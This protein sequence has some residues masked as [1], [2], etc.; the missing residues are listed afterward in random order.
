MSFAKK[1]EGLYEMEISDE[2]RQSEMT[3]VNFKVK[4][5]T[6]HMLSAIAERFH[7][8][9]HSFGGEILDDA[10]LQMFHALSPKDRTDLAEKADEALTNAMLKAG[11]KCEGIS[12]ALGEYKNQ[13]GPWR[14]M[15]HLCNEADE[16]R[17]QEASK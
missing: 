14:V 17:N 13:W 12:V 4:A 10:C 2:I 3:S 11:H 15:A 16:K 8:N 9:R 6:A 5:E 7:S 1:I